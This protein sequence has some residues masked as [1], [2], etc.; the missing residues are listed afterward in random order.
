[1]NKTIIVWENKDSSKN[2]KPVVSFIGHKI[3]ETATA[4]HVAPW[5]RNTGEWFFK[6]PR[7]RFFVK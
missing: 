2:G 3:S 7:N 4:V 5:G 1:M 6:N